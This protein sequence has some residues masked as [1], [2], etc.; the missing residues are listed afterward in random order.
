MKDIVTFIPLMDRLL[1]NARKLSIVLDVDAAFSTGISNFKLDSWQVRLQSDLEACEALQR[2][3]IDRFWKISCATSEGRQG[4]RAW[5]L[6]GEHILIMK[7]ILKCYSQIKHIVLEVYGDP[8]SRTRLC[9]VDVDVDI[10]INIFSQLPAKH[11]RLP[12]PSMPD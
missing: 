9:S 3:R 10:Y 12:I 11:I 7:N 2:S 8:Q 4:K 6:A 5:E 1:T